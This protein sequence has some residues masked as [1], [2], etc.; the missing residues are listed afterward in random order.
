MDALLSQHVRISAACAIGGRGF[1][2][3]RLRFGPP[4]VHAGP[5]TFP[6]LT[7]HVTFK[8]CWIN[9]P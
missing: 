2:T 4:P 7:G 8:S 6:A 9:H 3:A 5:G 1:A